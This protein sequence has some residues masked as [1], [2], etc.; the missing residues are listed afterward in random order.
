MLQSIQNWMESTYHLEPEIPV[1]NFLINHS[2]LQKYLGANHPLNQAE[3]VLLIF[4]QKGEVE[5]G[6]YLHPKFREKSF[7][8]A[9]SHETLTILEG[10]SHLL[11]ALHRFRAGETLSQLELELQAE[12]DKF[13][14]LR[15][16]QEKFPKQNAWIHLEQDANLTGL[17]ETQKETYKTAR[18]LACRYCIELEKRYLN[19]GSYDGLFHELR[20]FYRMSHWKK[21]QT[22]GLP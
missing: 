20:Q 2:L 12:I 21:L 3:E 11:L 7:G 4:N 14:F 1:S 15:I 5:L 18:R 6:L 8:N 9:T 10:V 19:L 22:I 17:S 16:A 13:L